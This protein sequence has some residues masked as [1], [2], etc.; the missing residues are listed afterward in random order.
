MYIVQSGA[1]VQFEVL[2]SNKTTIDNEF[3][4]LASQHIV[5]LLYVLF[6]ILIIYTFTT[7][8]TNEII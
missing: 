8:I 4:G 5:V 1:K 2:L 7:L 6:C 3:L